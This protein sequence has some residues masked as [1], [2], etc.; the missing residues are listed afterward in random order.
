MTLNY[1]KMTSSKMMKNDTDIPYRYFNT[2]IVTQEG[3]SYFPYPN[4]FRGEYTSDFPIV[5]EREAG[6]RPRLDTLTHWTGEP[7]HPYPHHCFRSGIKTKYPCNPE[8]KR[9][10]R[11]LLRTNKIFLYR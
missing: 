10:D 6:F 11:T 1:V 7:D 3:R 8:D 5:V 9:H 2:D 4:W